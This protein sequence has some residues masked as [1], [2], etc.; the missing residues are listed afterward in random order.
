M[1]R[2][3]FICHTDKTPYTYRCGE[4]IRFLIQYR[5]NGNTVPAEQFKWKITAD[6]GLSKEGV[7]DGRTGELVLEASLDRPGFIYVTVTATNKY[8][9]PYP[10]S[11]GFFGGAGV[12][13]EKIR[14]VTKEPADYHAFWNACKTELLAVAPDIIEKTV[15]PEDI[16]HPNHSVYDIK[17]TWAGGMPLS[18]ILTVPK[19]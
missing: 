9:E 16:E 3:Y 19:D 4:V 10:E 13:I 1:S 12:E 7:S 11:D 17:L 18:G 6:F 5:E 8:G 14:S 15:L 2:K